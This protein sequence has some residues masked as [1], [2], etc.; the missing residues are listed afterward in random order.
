MSA[1]TLTSRDRHARRRN[2]LLWSLQGRVA[3]LFPFAG[4][5]KLAMPIAALVQMTKL[6]GA[7]MRFIAV[8]ELVGAVGLVLPGLVRVK[9]ELTPLAAAGL[10]IIMIGATTLTAATQAIAP[11][12]IPFVVGAVLVVIIRGRREWTEGVRVPVGGSRDPRAL[13]AI[14]YNESLTPAE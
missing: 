1:T 2:A 12:V 7:F 9:Q 4:G 8:A 11:A 5:M 6:S 13:D 10:V 14:L 3:G